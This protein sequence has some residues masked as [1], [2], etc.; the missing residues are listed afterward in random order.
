[1]IICKQT[2]RP[3]ISTTTEMC[4]FHGGGWQEIGNI[5]LNITDSIIPPH[6]FVKEGE[7]GGRRAA[8]WFDFMRGSRT[9]VAAGRF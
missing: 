7:F 2:G 3:L 8:W 4:C 6:G 5:T 1:M 9:S